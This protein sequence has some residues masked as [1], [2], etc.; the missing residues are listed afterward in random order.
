MTSNYFK[1]AY[2][3][4]AQFF[5]FDEHD[6]KST[7]KAYA[8]AM[9]ARSE[10]GRTHPGTVHRTRISMFRQPLVAGPWS[11][12]TRVGEVPFNSTSLS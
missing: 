9:E 5:P 4:K 6:L 10:I 12:C 11:S 1:L 8:E 7:T 3:G 2:F